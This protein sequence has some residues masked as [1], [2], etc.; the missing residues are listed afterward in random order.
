MQSK[1]EGKVCGNVMSDW[2]LYQMVY[3]GNKM[4]HDGYLFG[5]SCIRRNI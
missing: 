4:V 3:S 1:K 5:E 2:E